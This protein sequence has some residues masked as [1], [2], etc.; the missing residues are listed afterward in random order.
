MSSSKGR[1][2]SHIW[3]GKIKFMFQTTN[4]LSCPIHLFGEWIRY[5]HNTLSIKQNFSFDLVLRRCRIKGRFRLHGSIQ[6]YPELSRDAGDNILSAQHLRCTCAIWRGYSEIASRNLGK[7][8]T[9]SLKMKLTT[10]P[11]KIG[12]ETWRCSSGKPHQCHHSNIFQPHQ[13]HQS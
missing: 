9:T 11:Q 7:K 5:I 2:T 6:R 12:Q 3:N 10:K 1:M 13:S 4:Q 8:Q